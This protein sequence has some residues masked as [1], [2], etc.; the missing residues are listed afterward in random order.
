[1]KTKVCHVI[2]GLGDGG[3]EGVLHRL[4]LHSTDV[5]HVVIS[6]SGEGKY[7][8]SLRAS[9][10]EVYSLGMRSG[11][12]SVLSFFSIVRILRVIRPDVVQTWMYHSDVLGGV[13]AKLAGVSRVMWCVR[14]SVLDAKSLRVSAR[15]ISYIH[16]WLS[17]SIP[18]KIIFCARKAL[19]MH[20]AM[21]YE[22]AKLI[23]IQNGIDMS[24]FLV[25]GLAR[26]KVRSEFGISRNVFL[27]GMVAR[28]DLYKDHRT[29]FKA[30]AILSKNGVEF[31]CLLVGTGMSAD[32]DILVSCAAEFGLNNCLI[33]AGQ[34]TDI[35]SL[36]NAMD[37]H[38]L[39]SV[40]EG[41]PN[42]LAESMACGTPCI[43]T[44]VGD[45]GEILGDSGML[46]PPSD[47]EAFAAAITQAK[48]IL[49]PPSSAKMEWAAKCRD[50]IQKNF[51]LD[52]MIR[53]FQRAWNET[54]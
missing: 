14:H 53:D 5:K 52:I 19:E 6:L 38:V 10:V 49:C 42:V 36:M 13:A 47:A 1:M 23:V 34:R 22:R 33:F 44:D 39:S 24:R 17:F 29:L 12:F 31:R 45:A 50:R 54:A 18:S 32:N 28:F 21:G 35:P 15:L 46:V 4:C 11:D 41:F 2:N 3:A 43:S 20:A 25:D 16:R 7:G 9:G 30:L 27:I 51:S 40:S 48:G 8:A 26:E 37:L